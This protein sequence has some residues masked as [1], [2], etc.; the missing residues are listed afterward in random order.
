MNM[1]LKAIYAM[2]KTPGSAP[3]N[4]Y[5]PQDID[6][7]IDRGNNVL[8]RA[9]SKANCDEQLSTVV[10][11]CLDGYTITEVMEQT[12][13]KKCFVISTKELFG[14][15]RTRKA[16]QELQIRK[17]LM[18]SKPFTHNTASLGRLTGYRSDK[19]SRIIAKMPQAEKGTEPG[20][21][22]HY[23][24]NF[25]IPADLSCGSIG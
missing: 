5:T 25:D 15:V 2:N 13:V 4:E 23:R 10:K 1:M 16:N 21:K 19:V 11:M 14:L 12:G 22:W 17:I 20:L 24:Y 7:M 18:E 3:K 8:S 9:R 6:A